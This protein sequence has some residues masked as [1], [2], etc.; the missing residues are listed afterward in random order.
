[1]SRLFPP[2][3]SAGPSPGLSEHLVSSVFQALLRDSRLWCL[4]STRAHPQFAVA[5]L[6]FLLHLM[7]T[8]LAPSFQARAEL[9]TSS[10]AACQTSVF[11]RRVLISQLPFVPVCILRPFPSP[12]GYSW[13]CW[14]GLQPL[15]GWGG[16][17]PPSFQLRCTLA[18]TRVLQG[19]SPHQVFEQEEELAFNREA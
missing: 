3:F 13:L 16:P 4:T 11:D 9:C 1:M 14:W 5:V 2:G 19:G 7:W 18:R 6:S 12:L 10:Q 17:F 15:Q 8:P